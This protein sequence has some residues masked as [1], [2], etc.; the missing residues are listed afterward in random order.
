M[1]DERYIPT[2][3]ER[4]LSLGGAVSADELLRALGIETFRLEG[5][6]GVV[7]K[8]LNSP[9][10]RLFDEDYFRDCRPATKEETR[11]HEQAVHDYHI[12]EWHA[13]VL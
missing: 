4:L 11:L 13:G 10:T 1:N 3:E 5:V 2:E 7:A 6:A 8:P 12:A 9:F